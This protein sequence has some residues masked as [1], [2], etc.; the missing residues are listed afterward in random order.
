MFENQK[1]GH[2]AQLA[3]LE[4][5]G[6]VLDHQDREVTRDAE[7]DLGEHRVNVGVP[8][9]EP[10]AQRLAHVHGQGAHRAAIADH[11]DHH[12]AID[13]RAQ[14]FHFQYIEQEAGKEGPGAERNHRQVEEDPQ[15]EGKAII[16]VGLIESLDQAQAG[17][18]EAENQHGDPRQD[19]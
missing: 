17:A 2:V 14:L 8:E 5:D 15:T 19:P 12:G 6:Q 11:A 7:G 9:G 4:H 13:D 1:L 18:I 10:E 3:I 16:H